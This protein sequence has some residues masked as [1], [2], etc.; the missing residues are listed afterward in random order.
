MKISF[1]E[2]LSVL[3]KVFNI[4]GSKLAKGINIDQSLVYK[5]LRNERIPA[6]DSPYINLITNY[7]TDNLNSNPYIENRI[8]KI[9]PFDEDASLKYLNVKSEVRNMLYKA[10]SYSLEFK[11]DKLNILTGYN[12]YHYSDKPAYSRLKLEA[13]DKSTD[14]VKIIIGIKAVFDN[15][16]DLVA[17]ASENRP[18]NNS[19]LISLNSNMAYLHHYGSINIRWKNALVSAINNGWKVVFLVSLNDD[20]KRTIKIIEDMQIA[21]NTNRLYVYYTNA[22]YDM[23]IGNE[24][25]IVPQ[26]GA[27]FCFSSHIRNQVDSAFLFQSTESIDALA[28][29]FFQYFSSARPLY[30]TYPSQKFIEF[31]KLFANVEEQL[32]DRFVFKG[33]HSTITIPSSLYE[34]YIK[35]SIKKEHEA[36]QRLNLHRKRIEAFKAQVKYYLFRD[37]WFK[38]SI[39]RLV[40]DKKYF[41]DENYILGNYIPVKEDILSHIKNIIFMLQEYKNYE[42]AIVSEK[43]YE[44]ICKICWMVKGT[45]Y[46]MIEAIDSNDCTAEINLAITEEKAVAAYREY[47]LNLWNSIPQINKNKVE[48]I[49]WLNSLI[50]KNKL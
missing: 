15:I 33:G 24:L 30:N 32:G 23:S 7:L 35:H 3:L 13:I 21:L 27:L 50:Q 9:L 17:K 1:G 4:N 14:K 48:I 5:W 39:E 20:T 19:I 8:T 2:C 34:K 25:V 36:S 26:V 49:N 45:S 22:E 28:G 37:I 16:I 46:V 29:H 47:Y 31:Q 42:V 10:Q 38:E 18:I 11:N 40:F 6:F 43:D 44:D 41:F 12:T